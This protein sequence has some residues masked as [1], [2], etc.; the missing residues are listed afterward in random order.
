MLASFALEAVLSSIIFFCAAIHAIVGKPY[1]K[2]TVDFVVNF[3]D[4][5]LF[6]S[7][8]I[9]IASI[10]Y[11]YRASTS[12]EMQLSTVIA[13]FAA[14]PLVPLILVFTAMKSRDEAVGVLS[15][16]PRVAIASACYAMTL[17]ATITT[18]ES[19]NWATMPDAKC[20]GGDRWATK[21]A[22]T[23]SDMTYGSSAWMAVCLSMLFSHKIRVGSKPSKVTE[24][25]L[26]LSSVPEGAF[27]WAYFAFIVRI[28]RTAQE[29]DGSSFGDKYWG[30]GQFLSVL[31]LV[32]VLAQY[33]LHKVG[34]HVKEHAAKDGRYGREQLST[35]PND[36][37]STESS[38]SRAS[39]SKPAPLGSHSRTA[40]LNSAERNVGVESPTQGLSRASSIESSALRGGDPLKRRVKGTRT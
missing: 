25:V 27:M 1:T 10:V 28:R 40:T 24:T 19:Q 5:A 26:L 4:S 7:F 6:F 3:V 34:E 13:Q 18:A 33:A 36:A 8:S 39:S 35:R 38:A 2:V 16:W 12:Y 11:I 30:Y 21:L 22:Q 15:V 9:S 37:K 32:Q 29:Y 23:S 17:F 31:I 14:V 20:Y